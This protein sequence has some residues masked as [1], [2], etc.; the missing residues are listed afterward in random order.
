MPAHFFRRFYLL[1]F[2][3]IA[4]NG[5]VITRTQVKATKSF[6]SSVQEL[7]KQC[8]LATEAS[9][10]VEYQRR[11]IYPVS[12]S[13]DSLMIEELTGNYE[14]LFSDDSLSE[15]ISSE[16]ASLGN[17]INGFNSMLPKI[18]QPAKVYDR[19]VLLA[20]ENFS[21]Y[22][23]FGVGITIYKT[24]YDLISYTGSFIKIPRTR[25]LIRNY[26]DK[27]EGVIILKL[28]ATENYLKDISAKLESEKKLIKS[29]YLLFLSEQN[30]NKSPYDYYRSYNKNFMGKY[31]LASS[32]LE[33]TNE[34]IVLLPEVRNCY[35]VLLSYNKERNRLK[36]GLP[37]TGY[38][39]GRV[40]RAAGKY[41]IAGKAVSENQ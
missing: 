16:I 3:L 12:F 37:C 32:V 23:P 4:L 19:G 8:K 14:K 22:L 9:K 1:F 38:L 10:I 39:S 31:H 29:N 7:D 36:G 33:L 18:Q 21:S 41:G 40:A 6:F 28:P 5:C 15:K 25:K 13:D 30:V 17:Y 20:I 35:S 24:L 34:L 2:V 27:G 11:L 26:V